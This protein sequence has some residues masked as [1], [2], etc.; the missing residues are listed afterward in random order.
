MHAWK[1]INI[2][3]YPIQL[4]PNIEGQIRSE[5][6]LRPNTSRK[7]KQDARTTAAKDFSFI[8]VSFHLRDH[9]LCRQIFCGK[10]LL[11]KIDLCN[12]SAMKSLKQSTAKY[13]GL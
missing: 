13:V 5:I 9:T 10:I 11:A 8:K 4:E 1:S 3:D 6:T 12:L 7:W 2:E